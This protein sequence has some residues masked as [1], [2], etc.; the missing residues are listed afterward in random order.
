M[1]ALWVVVLVVGGLTLLFRLLPV[2]A[3]QRTGLSPRAVDGLRHAGTGA[4]AALVVLG[5][6]GPAG[7]LRP[8]PAF[9]AAVAVGGLLAWRGWSMARVVLAGGCA[10]AVVTL[11]L[12]LLP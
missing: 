1:S 9:L 10:Y 3:V 2:V 7:S 12:A 8:Q 6:L 11:G 4:V 5:V